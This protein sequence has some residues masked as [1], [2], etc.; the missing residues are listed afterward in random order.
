MVELFGIL[1]IVEMILLI[2]TV[3]LF[4]CGLE[5]L[6]AFTATAMLIM[7]T[8]L[9]VVGSLIEFENI[10]SSCECGCENCIG[11]MVGRR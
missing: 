1:L 8:V 7:I 6:G 9:F 3:L 10:L 2:T 4:L 5:R 11:E